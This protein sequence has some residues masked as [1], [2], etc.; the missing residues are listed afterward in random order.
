[1]IQPGIERPIHAAG[2]TDSRHSRSAAQAR[3]AR[4]SSSVRSGKSATISWGV[5]PAA[6]YSKTSRTVMRRPRM[7]AWPLRLSDSMVMRCEW[8]ITQA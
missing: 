4:M 7:Q 1:M 5:I 2:T 8:S 3:Q 6:R